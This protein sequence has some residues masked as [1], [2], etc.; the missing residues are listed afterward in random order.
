MLKLNKNGI[1]YYAFENFTKANI[2]HGFP[3][4][5]NGYS[6]NYF[7]SLNFSYSMGDDEN[8]VNKN[9]SKVFDAFNINISA[10]GEQTHSNN[11]R[12]ATIDNNVNIYKD[13]DGFVTDDD[14]ALFTFHAD[15]GSVFMYDTKNEVFGLVHSGWR[16]TTLKIAEVALNKLINNFNSSPK[17][18]LIGIGP[19]ICYDCFEVDFD[20]ANEF[21]NLGYTKFTKYSSVKNKYFIDIKN[22]LKQQCLDIGIPSQNIEVSNLCTMC[23]EDEFFSH[24][25]DGLNR[26]THLS[27]IKKRRG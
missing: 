8:N 21:I 9:Y 16:G 14:I 13:T 20:V 24:R 2:E 5:K 25:R 17:D 7:S 22:I 23:L 3:N 18:I 19:S 11:V 12:V 4:R 26:G 27:F 6:K 10:K 15:C 1:E